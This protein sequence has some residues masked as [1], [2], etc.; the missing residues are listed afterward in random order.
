[1]RTLLH[2]SDVHFGRV[3]YD[4]V[5][6]LIAA[7][8]EIAPDVVVLSGDL[9]QRATS[10][11]YLEAQE[12]LAELPLPQIVVPGNHDIPMYNPIKRFL[13][14]LHNFE[15]YITNDLAPFY[16]DEEIAI[17]GIN[18]ARS[19]TSKYGRIN[20]KQVEEIRSRFA[21][22]GEHVF[23]CVVTHHPFELPEGYIHQKQLIGRSELAMGE[24]AKVGIDMFLSGHLHL[25]FFG[26]TAARY[27]IDNYSA[28]IVEAGTATSTRGRG[29]PNSFNVIVL[30][31]P[32]IRVKRYSWNSNEGK[33]EISLEQTFEHAESGWAPELSG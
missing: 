28:L 4:T 32:I 17:I 14:P 5:K 27:K 25:G 26:S 16:A 24:L 20:M 2:L 7:A 22:A 23:R 33:F 29:E 19:L 21:L 6:P 13:R 31:R 30:D 3:D 18:S 15:K 1:M 11:Q 12:F 8:H 9:T 10:A